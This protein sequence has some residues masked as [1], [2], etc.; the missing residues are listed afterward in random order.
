ME[1]LNLSI[2]IRA[3]LS[4]FAAPATQLSASEFEEITAIEANGIWGGTATPLPQEQRESTNAPEDAS[5]RTHKEGNSQNWSTSLQTVLDRPPSQ[6]PQKLML[7]G[8]AFCLAFGTWATIGQIDQVSTAQGELV[9]QGESYKIHPINSGKVASIQ[10]E[11]GQSVKAGDVLA[12]LDTELAAQEV[13]RLEELL[14]ADRIQLT[15]KQALIDQI[16]QEA[17]TRE[18]IAQADIDAQKAAIARVQAKAQTLREQRD[19]LEL[20]STASQ[21]RLHQLEPLGAQAQKLLS[22]KQAEMA[23]QAERLEQLMPLLSEGAISQEYVFQAQQRLRTSQQS[24]TQSQLQEAARTEEQI[25]QAQQNLRDRTSAI[26]QTQGELQ[27]TLAE[28]DQLRAGLEQKRAEARRTYLETQERIQQLEFELTQL[29]AKIA[30]NRNLL[31]SAKAKLNQ[32]FLYAPVDGVVSSL[33]VA[34]V[35]EVVQPGQT[36][37][38]IAPRG[39]SLVLSASLPNRQAGLV[40]EGMPVKVKFDAYPYQDYGVIEG[41]VTSI[42]ADAKA[43]EQLGS[44]YQVE[45]ELDRNYVSENRRK[46]PFKAGQTATA[47]I[48]TRRRRIIDVLFEPIRQLKEGGIDM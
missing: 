9:P 23:A 48:V 3:P 11:E 31:A 8:L 2:A 21:Q 28:I 17:Q 46:I 32:R 26:A 13:E 1:K 44:V 41:E 45:V 12:E 34:N 39:A 27:Q 15:Q 30:E 7:G 43:D 16:R 40:E 10:V 5:P 29:N 22:Q 47:E 18:Q 24:I 6:L 4:R 37:A 20:E 25:F 33:N 14:S 36:V 42:S 38:E 19:R 35:G